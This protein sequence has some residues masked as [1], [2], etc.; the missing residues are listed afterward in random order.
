MLK[1]TGSIYLHC[2]PTASHYLKLLMDAVFGHGNFRN[3]IVWKRQSSHNRAKRWGPVHDCILY[4]SGGRQPI[5][6]RFPQHLDPEYVERFYRHSDGRGRFMIDNLT[7]PG[8]RDGD[9]GQTVERYRPVRARTPL[10]VA[11]GSRVAGMV[12]LPG[13]LRRDASPRAA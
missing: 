4:Y 1:D 9:T 10:G 5:W 3:E 6:N 11:A 2:D 12:R 7:G 8:L 13:R